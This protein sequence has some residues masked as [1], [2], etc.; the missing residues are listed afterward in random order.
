MAES[1]WMDETNLTTV[2]ALR[3]KLGM[4]LSR[5]HDPELVQ[6]EDEILQHYKEWLRFNHNEFGT[7]RTKGKEFYDLPDVIFFDFSTQ[8]PRPKFGA[9]FD[10]VDPY[11]DDSHLAC[12]DLEIVATS[13]VTGYATL[14]QRFWGTGTDG[15]EFSF[16]YRMTSLLRKVDGK[17]KWIHEHVSFPVDL[18][19]AVGDLTCQTGTTGKPTI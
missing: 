9:H 18:N 15:R 2:K 4:P 12:K 1:Q 14:I 3:E 19:T 10:S 8:I 17:W 5:H 11:Y 7:N 6:E 16:T 13:K